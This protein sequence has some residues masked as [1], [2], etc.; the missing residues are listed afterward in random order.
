MKFLAGE[1]KVK[2]TT[3]HCNNLVYFK[4]KSEQTR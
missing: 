4:E 1:N 3:Y 2:F